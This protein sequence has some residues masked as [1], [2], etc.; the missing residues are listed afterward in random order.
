MKRVEQ[1]LKNCYEVKRCHAAHTASL[2]WT[3]DRRFTAP[4]QPLLPSVPSFIPSSRPFAVQL[5]AAVDTSY[6][7]ATELRR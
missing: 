3:A 1:S 5:F 6:V 7:G 4:V 2:M